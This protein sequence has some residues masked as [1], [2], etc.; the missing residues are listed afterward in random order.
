MFKFP[1]IDTSKVDGVGNIG[2]ENLFYRCP[3]L[4]MIPALDGSALTRAISSSLLGSGSLCV[5]RSL[6]HGWRY[7]HTYATRPLSA[8][9]INEIFT[10]LGIADGV[11]TINITGCYGA[12]TC[13]RSIAT[14]K[15]WTVTG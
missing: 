6:A 15:G 1:A 7:K 8:E 3:S 14:G 11:Q 12:A 9:A 10:N 4:A 5:S 2:M 13:D